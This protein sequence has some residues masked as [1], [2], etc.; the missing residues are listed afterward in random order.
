VTAAVVAT[1][2]A[3]PATS[4][5][6][7]RLDLATPTL[8]RAGTGLVLGLLDPVAAP[9]GGP[10]DA[11]VRVSV[12]NIPNRTSKRGFRRSLQA[13]TEDRQDFVL[14]NEV[15]IRDL[16]KMHDITRRY[17]GYRDPVRDLTVGGSQSMNNVVLWRAKR[18]NL[19]DAGRVKVVDDDRGYR[20]GEAYT[21]D[22]YLTWTVLQRT[23]TGDVVS[24]VSLHMPTNPE[25]Y[26]KQP[27]D[28]KTSRLRTYKRGMD[29][30]LEVVDALAEHGPVLLGGDMNSHPDQ[31]RW[32]APSKMATLGYGWAKDPGVMYLFHPA[33]TTVR[34]QRTLD[35]DS[36]HPALLATV[37][38]AGVGPS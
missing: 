38:L 7:G 30:V 15:G 12:A 24:V 18:W 5:P 3:A 8:G 34:N 9:V 23:T 13:I 36:D 28:A 4:D 6:G 11:R 33:G 22:R 20:L 37:D 10:V 26:P 1:A 16:E 14:L 27:K 29:R 32:T 17:R 25:Y 19:V 31:G 2:A 35:I 21:W